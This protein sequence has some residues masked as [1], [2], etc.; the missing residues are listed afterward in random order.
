MSDALYI[1]GPDR[2]QGIPDWITALKKCPVLVL[3]SKNLPVTTVIVLIYYYI[4][5]ELMVA[6]GQ[7]SETN[8]A[9]PESL[10]YARATRRSASAHCTCARAAASRA[11]AR[12]SLWSWAPLC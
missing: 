2:P 8:Y 9:T 11:M 4:T 3:G 12:L 10:V 1:Y 6:H 5:A 7:I